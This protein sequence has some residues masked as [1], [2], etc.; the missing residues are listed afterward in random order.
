MILKTITLLRWLIRR[1]A[2]ALV[3]GIAL[4]LVTSTIRDVLGRARYPEIHETLAKSPATQMYIS[5]G[6]RGSRLRE[7]H[8]SDIAADQSSD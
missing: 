6:P 4:L 7:I 3:G 2:P 1:S 8:A 5:E